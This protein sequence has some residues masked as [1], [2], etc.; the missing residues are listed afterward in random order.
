M[1]HLQPARWSPGSSQRLPT[2]IDEVGMNLTSELSN[3]EQLA[4]QALS[5]W[6]L[7]NAQLDLIKRRENAVYRVTLPDGTQRA[8]RVHRPDYHT[9]EELNSELLWMQALNEYGVHTPKV[10]ATADGSLFVRSKA[11][12]NAVSRQCDMLA[13][14]DGSPLGS[15]EKGSKSDPSVLTDSYRTVGTIM[16]RLHN[17]SSQWLLPDGFARHAWDVDGI[18]GSNPVWGRFWELEA[19]TA[20]QV[21]LLQAA[22][23][24]VR[25]RLDQFGQGADRYG[26]I[27]ADFL[28]E[29]L[30]ADD[31]EIKLIDFDDAGFGWHLF[32][33]ATSVFFFLGE[34][35]FD[36]VLTAL[37]EG[38]RTERKMPDE[39]LD[40]L[41]TFL[42]AR[43]L[44]YIG[45]LHTRRE[46]DAAQQLTPVVV[47]GVCALAEDYCS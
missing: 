13:W 18:V 37:V 34:D 41:P 12:G 14:V 26:L 42:M 21:D 39:H 19:L 20:A 15:I 17:H 29:N 32:D 31:G 16:A 6:D 46:T 22:A 2:R 9:D 5:N 11:N 4:K 35:E 33:I 36:A 40:M 45:W 30:L 43:G 44:T 7:Q 24:V 47:R 8:L 28:P 38:Y 1:P 23:E 10:I 25:H 27:H 3:L